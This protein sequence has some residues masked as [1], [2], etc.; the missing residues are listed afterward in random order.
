MQHVPLHR[1]ESFEEVVQAVNEPSALAPV[2]ITED[3]LPR[4]G[5]EPIQVEPTQRDH[6]L[7]QR[8]RPFRW[9]K[10]VDARHMR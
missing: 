2:G 8:G 10:G 1:W 4:S 6:E 9:S 5:M 7:S 3:V